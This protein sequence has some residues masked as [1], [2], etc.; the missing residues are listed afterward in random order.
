MQ[1][2]VYGYQHSGAVSQSSVLRKTYALLALSFVPCALG[3]YFASATGF[4]LYAATG[5]RWIG[6][7]AV[8]VFF[9]GMTFLIE[10]NRYSNVGATLLMVFTFGMGVLI[11]P[12]LQYSLS[13][14]GGGNL[15]A[16]AALMTTAVF[17]VM[18]LLAAKTNVNTRGLGN[19]LTVGA[20]VLMVGVVVNMFMQLPVFSLVI[21]G[22]FVVFSSLMIMFNVRAVIEGGEDSHISAALSIFIS[23]YNVFSSLLHILLAFAN[24][25]D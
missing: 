19:F 7:I 4:N 9:Y 8:M 15:V 11:A 6:F 18:S 2:N 22:G 1:H 16:M 21:A 10:R 13:V 24:N 20:I 3:A 14:R 23:L 5:N 25:D 17:A 12:L